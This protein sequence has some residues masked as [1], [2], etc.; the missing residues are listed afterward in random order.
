MA[1]RSRRRSPKRRRRELFTA[2][3]HCKAG[4]FHFGRDLRSAPAG[5]RPAPAVGLGDHLDAA[6]RRE[7]D[8]GLTRPLLDPAA[9]AHLRPARDPSDCPGTCRVAPRSPSLSD[10]LNPRRRLCA[11][12]E[13][14]AAARRCH[15]HH[16]PLD[17]LE[18]RQRG[19]AGQPGARRIAPRRRPRPTHPGEPRAQF[20]PRP[21][22]RPHKRDARPAH[23]HAPGPSRAGGPAPRPFLPQMPGMRGPS[24]GHSDRCARRQSESRWS[25]RAR[26]PA[27]PPRRPVPSARCRAPCRRRSP[28]GRASRSGAARCRH[29]APASPRR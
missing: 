10:T 29:R 24:G 26:G 20:A 17:Q 5:L 21:A 23:R 27:A 19:A 8:D 7:I 22:A 16:A 6:G 18:R 14:D 15:A 25:C 13:I 4:R 1:P 28:A 11:E 3:P 12:I 9:H 2:R